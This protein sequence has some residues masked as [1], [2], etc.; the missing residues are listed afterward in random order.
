MFSNFQFVMLNG[1]CYTDIVKASSGPRYIVGY[2]P[3]IEKSKLKNGARV[4]LDM[5]TLTIMRVLP[6]E[7]DPMVF[8]MLKE[9]P[10][11]ASFSNVGGLN[12]QIRQIREV[13]PV[14]ASLFLLCLL[15]S[16]SDL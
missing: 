2:R 8:N 16:P 7:V 3:T 5:T 13:I 15:N 4:S 9:S 11:D 6:R 14:F 12:E 10:G 1:R